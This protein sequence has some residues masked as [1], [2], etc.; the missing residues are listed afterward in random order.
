MHSILKTATSYGRLLSLA[1]KRPRS[2][3]IILR[4]R[5]DRLTYLDMGALVSLHEAMR[6]VERRRN[7][8]CVIEAG[9]AL[10]GSA[11]VV[12]A[13]K[14]PD[15]QFFVYD[16]FGMIPPPSDQDGQDAKLRYQQIADGGSGG[17]KGDLYYGY[18]TNLLEEVTGNFHRYGFDLPTQQIKLIKG[19][20]QDSLVVDRPVAL[21][22][23]D[24]D[25]YESVWVCLERIV[26]NLVTGG[27]IVV[28]DY[29]DWSGCRRAVDEYFVH[30][31][32]E[33]I[34][35]NPGRLHIQRI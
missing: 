8:G 22:H 32:D 24:G 15:R 9:C 21:A 1:L 29:G 4:V 34:F 31:R 28:D 20:F 13:A 18:R 10:G 23:I 19:L 27:R 5:Q 14:Q 3:S 33:F 26:P 2:A 12:A 16:A 25:W 6:E 7:P 17:I 30:R 35:S 11:L